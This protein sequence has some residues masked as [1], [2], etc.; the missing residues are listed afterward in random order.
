MGYRKFFYLSV[1]VIYFFRQFLKFFKFYAFYFQLLRALE[2]KSE[3][4]FAGERNI[5]NNLKLF[6]LLL[7]KKFGR[8]LW[9]FNSFCLK[10]FS[11]RWKKVSAGLLYSLR[12]A[13]GIVFGAVA[14]RP[15]VYKNLPYSS[16]GAAVRVL[17]SS[18]LS[19]FTKNL[20]H[21]KTVRGYLRYMLNL[22]KQIRSVWVSKLLAGLSSANFNSH[23]LFPL[24]VN[25]SAA[26][27]CKRFFLIERFA[28][29]RGGAKLSLSKLIRRLSSGRFESNQIVSAERLVSKMRAR[30]TFAL[31]FIKR[32]TSKYLKTRLFGIDFV[33]YLSFVGNVNR[34]SVGCHKKRS[35]VALRAANY[36]IAGP[37][38]F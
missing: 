15:L 3:A 28:F 19:F 14:F 27:T 33:K 16:M 36:L 21:V 29:G 10:L 38:R 32:E 30:R 12:K 8:V 20:G 25:C 24:T 34:V 37:S 17:H 2:F 35:F 31:R 4:L 1:R 23:S 22:R 7:F 5:F 26:L 11:I 6:S 13:R 18:Y 9:S